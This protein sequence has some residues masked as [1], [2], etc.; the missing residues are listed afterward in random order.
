MP[1]SDCIL[2]VSL[3]FF[4]F[5]CGYSEEGRSRGKEGTESGYLSHFVKT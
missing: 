4:F 2:L 5:L 1:D 3:Q